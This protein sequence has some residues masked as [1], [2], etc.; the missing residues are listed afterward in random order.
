ALR[1]LVREGAE[2][3]LDGAGDAA[4]GLRLPDLA[5]AA[6]A[7]PLQQPVAFADRQDL[8]PVERPSVGSTA[9]RH[10]RKRFSVRLHRRLLLDQVLQRPELAGE[11]A[12]VSEQVRALA[13]ALADEELLIYQQRR[14]AAGR[15]QLGE[16]R[17]IALQVNL[18]AAP[19]AHLHVGLD[20]LMQQ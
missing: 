10:R 8:P 13:A 17:Q 1:L 9:R 7:E 5:K 14:Q 20:Q 4:R 19:P 2:D 16:A 15:A 12:D 11:A 3:D 18:L 6:R